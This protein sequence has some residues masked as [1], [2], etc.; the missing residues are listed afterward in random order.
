MNIWYY[1]EPDIIH[2]LL[3]KHIYYRNQKCVVYLENINEYLFVETKKGVL[4]N[5]NNS[6]DYI[7]M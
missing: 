1:Y 6:I 4:H 3:K 5:Y 2:T 7:K